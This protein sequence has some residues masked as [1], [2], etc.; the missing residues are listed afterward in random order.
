MFPGACFPKMSRLG[1]AALVP[2]S[3]APALDVQTTLGGIEASLTWTASNRTGSAGFGYRV[4]VKIDAGFYSV[5]TTTT[6]LFYTHYPGSPASETYTYRII[7]FNDYGEG[8]SSNEVGV[9][10]PGESEGPVLTGPGLAIA[11]D[12]TLSWTSIAGATSY[13]LYYSR[14][15]TL[16]TLLV[17]TAALEYEVTFDFPGMYHYVIAKN[18]SSSSSASNTVYVI[19]ALPSVWILDTGFWNDAGTWLDTSNWND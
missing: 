2:P 7:P 16:F 8:L 4:E 15:N 9:V 5:L 18:G 17:N 11:V 6:D 1:G 12:Y 13:D 19:L 10:L 3:V 14:D